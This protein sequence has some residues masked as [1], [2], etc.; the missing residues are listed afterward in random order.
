MISFLFS[1][2]FL[3]N[4]KYDWI[5]IEIFIFKIQFFYRSKKWNILFVFIV[6]NYIAW[7]MHHDNIIVVIF[8]DFVKN[9]NFFFCTS[10]SLK[11]FRSMLMLNNAKIHWNE[12]L[13]EMC[14]TTDVILI[15]LFSYSSDFNSIETSFVLLKTW[16]KK[17]EKQTESYDDFENFLKSVIKKQTNVNDSKNLFRLIDIKYF[18]SNWCKFEM[19]C[20]KIRRKNF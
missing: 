2:I 18:T 10:V 17:N 9:Q 6:E 15:W 3:K 13:I 8:N 4:R 7:K 1:L 19:K 5:L 12:K 14:E 20:M 11:N 16:I